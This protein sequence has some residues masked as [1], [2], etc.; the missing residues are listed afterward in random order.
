MSK[1][2]LLNDEERLSLLWESIFSGVVK[3]KDEDDDEKDSD[4]EEESDSTEESSKKNT[5]DDDDKK[6]D[7]E[8]DGDDDDEEKEE[9]SSKDKSPAKSKLKALQRQYNEL[10]IDLFDKYAVECIETALDE[11]EVSFGE[12]IEC[13]LSKALDNLKCKILDDL[14]IETVASC[15]ES[16]ENIEDGESEVEI[17]TMPPA[18]MGSFDPLAAKNMPMEISVG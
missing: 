7:D 16:P 18:A 11:S 2:D 10:L 17:E 8:D 14:G 12:N 1:K 9:S 3:S 13:I 15:G 6:E 4:S 5:N